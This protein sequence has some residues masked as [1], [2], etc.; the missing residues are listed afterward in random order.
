MG[1]PFDISWSVVRK[2]CAKFDTFVTPVTIQPKSCTKGADYVYFHTF[3]PLS[4][5]HWNKR[6]PFIKQTKS[7]VLN[8]SSG[9]KCYFARV[10][11]DGRFMPFRVKKKFY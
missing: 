7:A 4:S 3:K 5:G 10:Y 8:W 6:T 11:D 9:N 1:T 2:L